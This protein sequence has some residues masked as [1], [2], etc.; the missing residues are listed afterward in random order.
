MQDKDIF[1]FHYFGALYFSQRAKAKNN[2]FGIRI[3]INGGSPPFRE[4]IVENCT[5][6]MNAKLSPIPIPKLSPIPPLTFFEDR[7]T[8]MSVKIKAEKGP[9]YRLYFSNSK[10]VI[11]PVPRVSSFLIRWFSSFVSM[12][13]NTLSYT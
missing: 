2:I 13:V 10:S 1:I 5:R 3:A 7:E 9:I 8:P 6:T 12:A 4:N 11:I